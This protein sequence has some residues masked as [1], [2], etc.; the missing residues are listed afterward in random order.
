MAKTFRKGIAVFQKGGEPK[1]HDML[2]EAA[3]FFLSQLLTTRMINTLAVRI[4]LRS[5]KLGKNTAGEVSTG[6]NGSNASKN[7]TITLRRDSDVESTLSS[8][9]HECVHIQQKAMGRLQKRIWKSDGQMHVRWE[10]RH[11]GPIDNIRYITRPW[12]MEARE[13]GHKLLDKWFNRDTISECKLCG[14]ETKGGDLCA[15]C[16]EVDSR[17]RR[18]PNLA[19]TILRELGYTVS[20]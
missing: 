5:S 1:D 2:K 4:E 14:V 7:F 10:G 3:S 19:V 12:E 15:N 8:L 18:D 13:K 9:A 6:A 11:L 17:V 16:W 20:K